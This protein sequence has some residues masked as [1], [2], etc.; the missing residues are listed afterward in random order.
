MLIRGRNALGD[1]QFIGSKGGVT[2]KK[3]RLGLL[4]F[5][6]VG[7]CIVGFFFRRM[8]NARPWES[9]IRAFE[10]A[11]RVHPPKLGGIIFTGSSSIK[12]WL[13]LADDMKPLYVLN[14]GFGGSQIADVNQY[15]GRIVIPYKPRAVVLYAGE[16]D[17][18]GQSKSPET[19][20]G[21]FKRFV[22]IIH[23]RLPDTWI[24][25][26]SMKPSPSRWSYWDKLKK[27]NQMIEAFCRTQDRVQFIDVTAVMLNANGQPRRE[28]FRSDNLHMN[29]QGYSLWTAIIKPVL[30]SR[31]GSPP[32]SWRQDGTG[33]SVTRLDLWAGRECRAVAKALGPFY[34]RKRRIPD[35]VVVSRGCQKCYD[36]QNPLSLL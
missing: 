30:Q 23:S 15:A 21:D 28:L 22:E 24:Y 27:T 12:L 10:E 17:L 14:R 16:N 8:R 18:S 2:V 1:S 34:S 25:Y 11:D 35:S 6:L 36:G 7:C 19:V 13:T 32:M 31:F 26:V 9:S 29:A 4:V 3:T 33:W 5:V 20:S